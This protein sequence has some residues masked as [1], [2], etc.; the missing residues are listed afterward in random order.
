MKGK[1][2]GK[3][4][5]LDKI[6][7]EIPENVKEKIGFYSALFGLFSFV[8]LIGQGV[9]WIIKQFKSAG[10]DVNII[11]WIFFTCSLIIIFCLWK[12]VR[13]YKDSLW[14][15]KT[16]VLREYEKMIAGFGNF[17]FELLKCY[18]KNELSSDI[19]TSTVRNYL[20]DL[21][22]CICEIYS[23][24]TGQEI[25][26]CIKIIGTKEKNYDYINDTIDV[27]QAIIHT[28][29]RSSNTSRE[30]KKKKNNIPVPLNQNTDFKSII[31]PNECNKE[32]YFYVEDLDKY[33]KHLESIGQKYENTTPNFINLYKA[34][35]VVPIMIGHNK[36]HFT[37]I[38]NE[39]EYHILGFLCIDTL[40]QSAFIK[41]SK[42]QFIDIA[43][44]F[45]QIAYL[46]LN[47]YKYYYS[48]IE[49]NGATKDGKNKC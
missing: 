22:D 2:K 47:K 32:P 27:E 16:T 40:S 36:L 44:A 38:E 45:A 46:V 31:Q 4:E 15:R 43:S 3:K 11:P 42:T 29:V 8:V 21:L 34:T 25:N 24:Y 9:Y 18:K 30:R 1:E 10:T 6:Y 49:R 33:T 7:N 13:Q 41:E 19:L 5:H 26:S 12:K 20:Q 14:N 35:I 23:V 48:K 37:S 17:Y 28:F 39:N